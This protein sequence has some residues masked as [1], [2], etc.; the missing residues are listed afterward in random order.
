MASFTRILQA[1]FEFFTDGSK[2]FLCNIGNFVYDQLDESELTL[3]HDRFKPLEEISLK[4]IA[5]SKRILD[6]KEAN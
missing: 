3:I 1:D 5:A 4:E 2:F 6:S